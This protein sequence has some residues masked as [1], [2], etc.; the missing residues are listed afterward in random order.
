MKILLAIS[1]CVYAFNLAS[2]AQSNK[3]TEI[4]HVNAKEFQQLLET[5]SDEQLIDV[6][7][8]EEFAAGYLA[9]AQ[10]IDIYADDF[11]TRINAL[12]KSKPVFVYCKAGGRSADACSFMEKSGFTKVYDMSGGI[13]AWSH[14][15]FDIV[16]TSEEKA[17]T[18]TE[19]DYD[20]LIKTNSL[21]LIDYYAPWCGPC[22]KMEP[23]FDQLA[24][25]F[26][27]KITVVRINVD[28]AKS[29]SKKLQVATIPVIT[30]I[31]NGVETTRV[32]GFQS[33]EALRN[34]IAEL[35]K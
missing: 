27:G 13:M 1:A 4:K 24:A 8:T 19:S 28:E 26:Q 9:G 22:K 7:T 11:E 6:R 16:K 10:N 14:Q 30:T 21:L 17:D 23:I 34:M 5:T 18:F 20:A 3:A 12:D 33:E 2:C 25:E 32:N 29:L 31:K 15:N 35:L